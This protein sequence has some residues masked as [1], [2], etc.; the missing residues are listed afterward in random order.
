MTG[1][2]AKRHPDTLIACIITAAQAGTNG[3]M[4]AA[5]LAAGELDGWPTAYQMPVNSVRYYVREHRKLTAARA[6]A[7]AIAQGLG[8]AIYT[9]AAKLTAEVLRRVN[10]AVDP[11]NKDSVTTDHLDDLAKTLKTLE[12]FIKHKPNRANTENQ[13]P[14]TDPILKAANAQNPVTDTTLTTSENNGEHKHPSREAADN[15]TTTNNETMQVASQDAQQA[16]GIQADWLR[17]NSTT[18]ASVAGTDTA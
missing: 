14:V 9:G 11:K 4:I 6:P 17:P 1:F 3:K 13:Q 10:E 7:E 2:P 5:Q 18:P 16:T 12:V 15:T 8:P